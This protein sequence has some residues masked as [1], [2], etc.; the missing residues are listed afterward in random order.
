MTLQPN[1]IYTTY[2]PGFLHLCNLS[3]KQ[4]KS[5]DRN[6]SQCPS[7][8]IISERG[9]PSQKQTSW[10]FLCSFCRHHG[11]Y[12]YVIVSGPPCCASLLRRPLSSLILITN[13]ETKRQSLCCMMRPVFGG[14]TRIVLASEK[15]AGNK[16]SPVVFVYTVHPPIKM[17]MNARLQSWLSKQQRNEKKKQGQ[18]GINKKNE[19]YVKPEQTEITL[20]P[21]SSGRYSA[22]REQ[23]VCECV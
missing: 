21:K 10:W 7:N 2:T 13:G 17:Q 18:K 1:F 23:C 11:L 19:L 14:S 5:F 15:T 9:K 16:D 3:T 12:E 4:N 6:I 20:I 8:I 22:G